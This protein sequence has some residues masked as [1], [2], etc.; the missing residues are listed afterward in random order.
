MWMIIIV[1]IAVLSM[2]CGD[3]PRC[4]VSHQETRIVPSGVCVEGVPS[5]SCRSV[6]VSVCDLYES[7]RGPR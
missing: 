3:R 1:V 4:L 2:S 7:E 6:R 5:C